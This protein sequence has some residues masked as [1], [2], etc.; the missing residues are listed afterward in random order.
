M[1][2]VSSRAA[3][4]AAVLAK[5]LRPTMKTALG[6]RVH[7]S[8]A[9]RR[10]TPGQEPRWDREEE[11]P[12]PE[13]ARQFRGDPTEDNTAKPALCHQS[14]VEFQACCMINL[15]PTIFARITTAISR[16]GREFDTD[17]RTDV[18]F[19]YVITKKMLAS[20]Y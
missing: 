14:C 7:R 15:R 3:P 20:C 1:R 4:A 6:H 13:P 17:Y 16:Y 10:E 8:R 5:Q 12:E 2:R 18:G 19:I 9:P 11:D